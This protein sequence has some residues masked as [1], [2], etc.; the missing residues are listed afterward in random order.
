MF[1]FRSHLLIFPALVAGIGL[2]AV[3]PLFA[4]NC[5][6]GNC[7]N[8]QYFSSNEY[9][10]TTVNR[11]PYEVVQESASAN[12]GYDGYCAVCIVNAGKWVKGSP[13]FASSY[14]G[15]TYYF[16]GQTEKDVFDK[17][18][19]KYVPALN[20]DCIVCYAK[21]GKRI[22]GS[23]HHSAVHQDR[24]YLFPGEK[25]KEMFV[26]DAASYV[27][28]DLAAEGKCTVCLVNANKSI[29]GKSEFTAIHNGLRYLFPSD[30][31]RQVFLADPGKYASATVP[32]SARVNEMTA[33][34][35]TD[36]VSATVT[37][38][39]NAGC[40]ACEFGVRPLGS[41]DEL[42]LAVK[43]ATG[44]VYII[45]N[46]HSLYPRTYADRFDGNSLSVT[47][48]VVQREGNYVWINPTSLT[49]I[50]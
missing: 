42:G 23:V 50:R 16:P 46:A 41:P 35:A 34:P 15:T 13:Q 48:Q 6:N 38:S 3:S 8:Q 30:A 17:A 11:I 1:R 33:A 22:A 25:E 44:T 43:S 49:T 40:A 28:S 9:F 14:D 7:P 36:A 12:I 45:E 10:H 39:G 29:M 18:P 37:V 5:P 27:D 21:A 2:T 26:Q 47:G 20:G 19:R 4:Q 31:E 24:I 32:T